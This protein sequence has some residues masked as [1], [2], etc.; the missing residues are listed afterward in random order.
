MPPFL[1]PFDRLYWVLPSFTGFLALDHMSP[2]VCVCVCV[3]VCGSRRTPPYLVPFDRLYWVLP[4]FTGLLSSRCYEPIC[5]CV[6]IS[7]TGFLLG[8]VG[9]FLAFIQIAG[10]IPGKIK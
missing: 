5:V 2:G 4:S 10:G 9:W 3:S 7:F 8:L 6:S 1:V